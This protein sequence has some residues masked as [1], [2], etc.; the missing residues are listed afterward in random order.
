MSKGW[1]EMEGL[2]RRLRSQGPG[3]RGE[4]AA[5]LNIA[6]WLV[7]PDTCNVP[8]YVIHVN[9]SINQLLVDEGIMVSC[10]PCGLES[11]LVFA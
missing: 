5:Q 9:Q 10:V 11:R 1:G 7:P 8:C 4:Q 2:R 6:Q 3:E